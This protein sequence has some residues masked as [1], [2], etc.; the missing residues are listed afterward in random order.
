MPSQGYLYFRIPP[1]GSHGV[2]KR[3][4]ALAQETRR[5]KTF[6]LYSNCCS[7]QGSRGALVLHFK[8]TAGK[9]VIGTAETMN[10]RST[11]EDTASQKSFFAKK[12]Q[13][14]A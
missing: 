12:S 9:E 13:R 6:I 3:Q 5:E 11:R 1:V 8:F 7:C 4:C 10:F 2:I 14:S